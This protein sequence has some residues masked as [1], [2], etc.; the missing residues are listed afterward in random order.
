[1]RFFSL[2]L[3]CFLFISSIL[4]VPPSHAQKSKEC[5]ASNSKNCFS[6]NLQEV[7]IRD[8]LKIMSNLIQKNIL[9]DSKLEGKVTV[10]AYEEIPI[11]RAIDFM[12]QILEIRGYGIIEEPYLLK[13]V[14]IKKETDTALV[15]FDTTPVTRDKPGIITRI[16]SIPKNI[17]I[18]E[19]QKL[20]KDVSAK[21]V[22]T[23]IYIPTSTMVLTGYSNSL[24]RSMQILNEILNEVKKNPE[25]ASQ[26]IHIYRAKNVEAKSLADVI[27]KL[28][29]KDPDAS[30][31][32][33]AKKDKISVQTH[34]ET[35][36]IVV[37]ATTAQWR[38]I[39]SIIEKLDSERKQVLLEVVIAEVNT[40]TL[41]EFGVTWRQGIGPGSHVQFGDQ[42]NIAQSGIVGTNG[43]DANGLQNNQTEGL[44][45]G[46][47]SGASLL[48]FLKANVTRENLNILSSPQILSL[49]NEESEI[50]VGESVPI[51]LG[52]TITT[53]GTTTNNVQY[54][55]VGV[56]LKVTPHV[57]S[58]DKIALD[59]FSEVSNINERATDLGSPR[60]LKR[61]IKTQITLDN[62]QTIVIGGLISSSETVSVRKVPLLGDIP[63]LG[64]LFRTR[65]KRAEKRNLMVFI[66][67][68]IIATREEAD[69]ITNFKHKKQAI[70]AET[71]KRK[72]ELIPSKKKSY[73]KK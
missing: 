5:S 22:K 25:L 66:T 56:M 71:N 68:Q 64:Y 57:N 73:R 42:A 65:T 3:S 53:G 37:T 31:Q 69:R 47:L 44:S 10:V 34:K 27:S 45:V 6:V 43:F 2:L 58:K 60:F 23:H 35:N 38:D 54:R 72:Q 70:F 41:N 9:V 32:R 11:S 18:K 29:L 48:S 26:S 62:K 49:D 16:V 30:N 46:L 55:D 24:A 1:M 14:P 19:L 50:T 7:Q 33:N 8:W 15:D 52:N 4:L 39:Q 28:E 61:N 12:R 40:Q 21:D 51:Q 63:V 36:S 17:D 13:V 20:V 67:P 59:I